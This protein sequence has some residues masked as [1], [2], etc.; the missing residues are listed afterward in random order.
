MVRE[1]DRY[2]LL[3]K[4]LEDHDFHETRLENLIDVYANEM[5]PITA[6]VKAVER[7]KE[8][9]AGHR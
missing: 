2:R 1:A 4:L 3:P 6:A 7:A 8:N 9:G 5:A